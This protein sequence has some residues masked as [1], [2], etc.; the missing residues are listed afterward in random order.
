M[1]MDKVMV[2]IALS[3]KMDASSFSRVFNRIKLLLPLK[4]GSSNEFTRSTSDLFHAAVYTFP[5][6]EEE[7]TCLVRSLFC[8]Y[9]IYV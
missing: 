2:L 5:T 9:Q 6:R 7:I 3:R 8:F 4:K 1:D